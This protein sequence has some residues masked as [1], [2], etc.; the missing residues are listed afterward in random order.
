MPFA[1]LLC[2]GFVH[3]DFAFADKLFKPILATDQFGR[4]GF[5]ECN[6][7]PLEYKAYQF[8]RVTIIHFKNYFLLPSRFL[9]ASKAS[10]KWI[11]TGDSLYWVRSRN[12]SY[13]SLALSLATSA[14]TLPA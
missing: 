3:L 8:K 10:R 13:S 4:N 2:C 12:L 6:S 11:S 5:A 1:V 14:D 9:S 7:M